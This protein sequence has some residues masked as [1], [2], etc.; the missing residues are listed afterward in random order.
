MGETQVKETITGDHQAY[1]MSG[2]MPELQWGL[3]RKIHICGIQ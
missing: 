1:A 2:Q 3:G